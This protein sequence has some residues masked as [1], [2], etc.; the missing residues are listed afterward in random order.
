MHKGAIGLSGRTKGEKEMV[1]ESELPAAL[2][3]DFKIDPSYSILSTGW[4]S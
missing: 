3:A 4:S 2:S 1:E